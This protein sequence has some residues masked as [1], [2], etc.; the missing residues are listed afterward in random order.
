M[1]AG[2]GDHD[3]NAILARRALFISAAL[4][5]IGCTTHSSPNEP[6]PATD[7]PPKVVV[8]PPVPSSEPPTD[9]ERPSWA[10]IMDA[11][12][13]L[14]V[15]VGLSAS[16]HELLTYLAS[17]DR[18][19]YDELGKIWTALPECS[20]S[21]TDCL[22]WTK[23]IEV[24]LDAT[25]ASGPLC[26]YSPEV[27]NTYLERQRAHAKYLR[28][29]SEMLLADLDAA[30]EAR[31]N[32]ADSEAWEAHRQRLAEGYPRPCLS[33]MAPRADPI[34]DA[35]SFAP[36]GAKLAT[37]VDATLASAAATHQHNRKHKAKLIVR[38]HASASE[39]DPESLARQRAEAVA[40]ALIGLGVDRREI[41]VRNY[42]SSLPI[43]SDPDEAALNCR[44]DFEVVLP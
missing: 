12:P 9:G 22:A 20:P 39:A 27:T 24:M 40:E 2:V 7:E 43:S 25:D 44:V 32:A 23:A 35:V 30:V 41:E 15:P 17:N 29:I 8:E 5:G 31:V 33:C 1:I 6:E 10:E 16:E 36:G 11:A 28:E 37:T 14:D 21:A 26:G 3:R 4:A 42:G 18:R 13:P 34:I 38:G 19:R